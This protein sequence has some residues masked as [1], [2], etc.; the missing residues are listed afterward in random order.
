MISTKLHL[1]H[2]S[3]GPLNELICM[4]DDI[5]TLVFSW[6]RGRGSRRMA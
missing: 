3:D 1:S 6:E 5:T 4:I 2:A